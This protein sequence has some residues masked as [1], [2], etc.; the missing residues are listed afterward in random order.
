MIQK[1]LTEWEGKLPRTLYLQ[2]N[3][4]ARENKN[5]VLIAYLSMLVEKKVFKK[6]K[7]GFLLVGHTHDQIDQMF[8]RFSVKLAKKSAF[9]LPEICEVLR[10]SYEPQPEVHNLKGT[11]DFCEFATGGDLGAASFMQ[12]NDH[13][14]QHQFKMKQ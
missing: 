3:N 8:S 14:S 12:L 11:Y 13:S 6:V 4:T 7:L 10:E 2:L 9:D 1:I 5:Q